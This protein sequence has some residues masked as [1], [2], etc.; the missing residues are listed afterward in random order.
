MLDSFRV[1][2][3][4]LIHSIQAF[5]PLIRKG[6]TKKVANISTGMA[7]LDLINA[8]DVE[9]AGPYAVSKAASNVVVSKYSAA[10]KQE[11]I[12]FLSISPGYVATER[13]FQAAESK[14]LVIIDER[15]SNHADESSVGD[16][17]KAQELGR[18]F[19]TYAPHFTRML[20][21]EES[22][23]SILNVIDQKS[24]AG[25]DGGK[26]ISHLGSQQWL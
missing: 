15:L 4:G 1:N 6:T 13:N 24:V 26:F 21:T 17:K 19:A 23:S 22:V 8:T 5:L 14:I 10:H 9:V 25:G 18:K 3:L 11:G 20:T 12:L 16:A 7:D 2:T